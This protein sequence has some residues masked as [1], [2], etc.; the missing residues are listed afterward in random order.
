MAQGYNKFYDHNKLKEAAKEKE[1]KK[2]SEGGITR[3]PICDDGCFSLK[4]D[5]EYLQRTCSKGHKLEAIK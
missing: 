2:K 1:E 4:V 3:C 5:G